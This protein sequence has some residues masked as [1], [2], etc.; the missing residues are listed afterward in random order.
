[1]LGSAG[2]DVSFFFS[3]RNGEF[4]GIIFWGSHSGIALVACVTSKL[5]WLFGDRSLQIH[6]FTADLLLI[7][8][9]LLYGIIT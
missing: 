9:P 7:Y 1:V 2:V 6:I 4:C 3:L 5:H 8:N